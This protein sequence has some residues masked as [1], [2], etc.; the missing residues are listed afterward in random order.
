M[1][2]PK[3]PINGV[4][5]PPRLLP[6]GGRRPTARGPG[7]TSGAA[8]LFMERSSHPAL[9]PLLRAPRK[10]RGPDGGGGSGGSDGGGDC[11]KRRSPQASA[12]LRASQSRS[13][14]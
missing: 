6:T 7:P 13:L 4:G 10:G 12:S 11:A 1:S 2:A 14:R 5:P 8:R 3:A 9:E